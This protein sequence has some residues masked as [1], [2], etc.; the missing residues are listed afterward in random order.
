MIKI[1]FVLSWSIVLN[2][3][4]IGLNHWTSNSH[5]KDKR[6]GLKT[7]QSKVHACQIE[8]KPMSIQLL[9][10][11]IL[12]FP[13]C[14]SNLWQFILLSNKFFQLNFDLVEVGIFG[15][16]LGCCTL[17]SI[18]YSNQLFDAIRSLLNVMLCYVMLCYSHL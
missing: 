7:V 3:G 17:L 5:N 15:P 14:L 11:C 18:V 1:P 9:L 4:N 6:K 2:F 12:Y 10:S 16:A 13:N 8:C